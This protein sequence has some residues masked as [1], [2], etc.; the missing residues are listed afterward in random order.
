MLYSRLQLHNTVVILLGN[1]RWPCGLVMNR[2]F[3]WGST[4]PWTGPGFWTGLDSGLD[5]WI[6]AQFCT[7][8]FS[9]A[10]PTSRCPSYSPSPMQD[11][12]F[13]YKCWYLISMVSSCE[14]HLHHEVIKNSVSGEEKCVPA[15]LNRS[16]VPRLASPLG[17]WWGWRQAISLRDVY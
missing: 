9:E 11:L 2:Q 15:F 7:R 12:D 10:R 4:I 5:S 1:R 3:T 16:L 17:S 13:Q 14:G 6:M 8:A